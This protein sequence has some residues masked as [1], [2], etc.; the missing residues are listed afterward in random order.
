LNTFP[1]LVNAG[2]TE[3]KGFEA[4]LSGNIAPWLFLRLGYSYNDAR[5]RRFLDETTEEIFDTDG[6]PARLPNGQPNPANTDGDGGDVSGNRLP[7]T[8]VHMF[9]MS[10]EGSRSVSKEMSV[11]ARGDLGYESKRFAQVDNLAWAGDSY[12]LNLSAGVEGKRWRFA[13]WVENA[14]D[15]DTPAVVSRLVDFGRALFVPNTLAAGNRLTFFR[16]FTI[17]APRRRQLGATFTYRF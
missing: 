5:F 16:D 15:D 14:L 3:I 11:F 12:N 10:L 9:N 17:S 8:P 6:R 13:L 1:F 7:Q 2:E 4:E